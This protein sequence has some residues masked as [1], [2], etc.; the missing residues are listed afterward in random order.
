MSEVATQSQAVSIGV[1]DS[2]SYELAKKVAVD[3]AAS[4]LVPKEF[5]QNPPNCMIALNMAARIGADP[6]MVMQN[7]YI[8]HGKPGWSSQFLIA[9]FNCNPK[10]SALRYEFKGK[11]NTDTWACRAYA[12]EKETGEV[13]RG[14]W[15]SIAIA[16]A[17]GWYGKNGSKWQTMPEQMLQYRAASW[18]IRAIAPE[19]AMGLQTSEELGDT[20]DMTQAG[21]GSYEMEPEP[22]EDINVLENRVGDSIG[23]ADE[24]WEMFQTFVSATAKSNE[25]SVRDLLISAE[26]QPE[27]F[28]KAFDNW[29]AK[30]AKQEEPAKDEAPEP[31]AEQP[32]EEEQPQAG[33]PD[34]EDEIAIARDVFGADAEAYEKAS[35]AER[36]KKIN[37]GLK[38][39][40]ATTQDA[41]KK[42]GKT[43]GQWTSKDRAVLLN[44]YRDL[45][46][47]ADPADVF[48]TS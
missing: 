14:S 32:Q 22:K 42:V 18:F 7:L 13:L 9:T 1:M 39:L 37:A 36:K 17:E 12:T 5:Q 33:A 38:S 28:G 19:I 6:M 35:A 20:I 8:V 40:G 3:L 47:G 45:A 43:Y 10:F 23:V 29:K 26:E 24:D 41:E 4:T 48:P 15:V 46:L 11:E 27:S 16:K 31:E 21:P 44:A 30:N 2:R 34:P 25:A